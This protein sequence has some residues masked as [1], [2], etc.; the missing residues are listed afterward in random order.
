MLWC[1]YCGKKTAGCKRSIYL[2]GQR[3]KMELEMNDK[4]TEV[5]IVA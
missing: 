4:K 5:R 1:G 2:S 3:N